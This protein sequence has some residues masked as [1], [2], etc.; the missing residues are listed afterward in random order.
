MSHTENTIRTYYPSLQGSVDAWKVNVI[1]LQRLI[2]HG[3]YAGSPTGHWLTA[4]GLPEPVWKTYI[5]QFDLLYPAV[6]SASNI[7]TPASSG[8]RYASSSSSYGSTQGAPQGGYK[9]SD[10]GRR[11]DRAAAAPAAQHPAAARLPNAGLGGG[12]GVPPQERPASDAGCIR[13]SH[14]VANPDMPRPLKQAEENANNPYCAYHGYKAGYP[15]SKD[16]KLIPPHHTAACRYLQNLRDA[17]QRHGVAFRWTMPAH[18]Q[19]WN[20]TNK[21]ENDRWVARN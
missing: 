2:L 3:S 8:P 13:Q 5:A 9:S 12:G 16:G 6:A 14:I 10:G 19:T 7:N 21:L 1:T 4:A 20:G 17:Q 11:P 18:G 15:L